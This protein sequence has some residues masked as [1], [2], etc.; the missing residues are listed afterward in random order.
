MLYMLNELELMQNC[1]GNEDYFT[2]TTNKMNSKITLLL[3]VVA[4]AL[5]AVVT[6]PDKEAHQNAIMDEINTSMSKEI[7]ENI[8]D[9]NLEIGLSLLGGTIASKLL[10]TVVESTLRV[11]NYFV[12]STGEISVKGKSKTV[13]VGCFGHVFTFFDADDISDSMDE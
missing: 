4:V 12:F 11:R 9:S 13:S 2:K 8:G 5:V 10:T 1:L 3:I 6:C 7:S